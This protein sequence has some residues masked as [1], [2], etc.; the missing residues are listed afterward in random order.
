MKK[1]KSI[2]ITG[3]C[4]FVG[5]NLAIYLQKKL[6]NFSIYSVDNLKKKYSKFNLDILKKKKIKNFKI[7]ISSSKFLKLKKK[8]NFIID[9]SADPAVENSKENTQSVFNNNL[10]TTLNILEKT[11]KD[12]SNIIFISSSRVYPII[13]SYRK[14]RSKFSS[15]FDENTNTNGV[16]SIYGFTKYASELLIK[17][18][19]YI[20][21]IKFII[22]R[23]GIITGPLQ[24]GKVEQGLVSLWLW[25][26]LN[27]LKLN[28][29]GYGGKGSQIRDI[30]YIDDFSLLIKKQILG[31]EKNNNKLFCIGG[32]RK[33]SLT[34]RQLTEKCQEITSNYLKIGFYKKTSKYDIPIFISS[35]KQIKKNYNWSPKTNIDEILK[36]NLSWMKK[37]YK[38]IKRFF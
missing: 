35:N 13:E 36:F 27:N 23:F 20:F 11:R 30:L 24:F 18:Y 33:N 21:D 10:K 16:K 4:G 2:L 9:C 15:N 19:S 8:F 29:I 31:F 17:E 22:N 6:K 28:Y 26:H 12:K 34:L 37:N 3:G 5:T 14:F 32:G 25:R 38:R 1:N 7:D